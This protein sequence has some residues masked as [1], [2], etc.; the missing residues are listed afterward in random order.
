MPYW[1]NAS[2]SSNEYYLL[3][4]HKLHVEPRKEER[5]KKKIII[6][7]MQGKLLT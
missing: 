1:H 4:P 7:L 5:R 3:F 2:T 6:I